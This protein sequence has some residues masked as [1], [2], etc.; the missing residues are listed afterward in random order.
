MIGL[1][2]F[3][4][5]SFMAVG[6]AVTGFLMFSL[7]AAVAFASFAFIGGGALWVFLLMALSHIPPEY[8]AEDRNR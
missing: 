8:F 2:L 7:R 1:V 5:P 3:G 6:F 4:P